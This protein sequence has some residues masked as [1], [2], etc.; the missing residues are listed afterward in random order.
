VRTEHATGRRP[1]ILRSSDELN[2]VILP[3]KHE[4]AARAR[5]LLQSAEFRVATQRDG[6]TAPPEVTMADQVHQVPA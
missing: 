6:V 2:D 1:R 5:Q 3:A 4:G